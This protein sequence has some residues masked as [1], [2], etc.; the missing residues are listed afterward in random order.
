MSATRVLVF[1]VFDCTSS[2]RRGGRHE[3]EA[4]DSL[5]EQGLQ[6]RIGLALRVHEAHRLAALVA[7]P[8]A[9]HALVNAGEWGGEGESEM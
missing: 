8:E 1:I 6:R 9:H 3:R 4:D 5:P 7:D 2:V